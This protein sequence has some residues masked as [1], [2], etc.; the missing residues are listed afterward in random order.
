MSK[1]HLFRVG[2]RTCGLFLE[3]FGAAIPELCQHIIGVQYGRR[4]DR[5]FLPGMTDRGWQGVDPSH[6]K[7]VT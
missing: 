4:V 5:T 1:A 2:Y 7:V 3:I 6:G